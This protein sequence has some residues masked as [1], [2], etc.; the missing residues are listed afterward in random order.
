MWKKFKLTVI[1][2]DFS[3]IRLLIVLVQWGYRRLER[4]PEKRSEGKI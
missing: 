4:G 3:V 2:A 1:Q